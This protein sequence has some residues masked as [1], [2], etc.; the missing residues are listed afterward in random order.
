MLVT[1]NVILKTK[2]TQDEFAWR[3]KKNAESVIN[4]VVLSRGSLINLKL[5]VFRAQLKDV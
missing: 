1:L 2:N 4:Y 5:F 3:F